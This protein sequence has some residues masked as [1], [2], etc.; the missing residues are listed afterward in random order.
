[1]S[2]LRKNRSMRS[3]AAIPMRATVHR[4]T[5]VNRMALPAAAISAGLAPLAY[6]AATI[7]PALTPV[8]QSTGM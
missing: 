2:N 6:A 3:L 4:A 8:M 1:L 7:A 5:S